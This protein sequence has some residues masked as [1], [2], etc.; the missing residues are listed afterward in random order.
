MLTI[1]IGAGLGNQLFMI[2]AAFGFKVINPTAKL[3]FEDHE[4][5]GDRPSY[6]NT[7][8]VDCPEIQEARVRHLPD[9]KWEK[10]GDTNTAFVF[11]NY[12]GLIRRN[13]RQGISTHITG[14][15]QNLRYLPDKSLLMK[16]FNMTE[17][18]DKMRLRFPEINFEETC[19][20]HFRLG[21]YKYHQERFPLLP[22]EYYRCAVE[23]IKKSEPHVKRIL[24]FNEASDFEDVKHRLTII[25]E[26][27]NYDIEYNVGRK[28]TDWEELVLM[29][30]CRSNIIANSTFSWW[31]AYL[32]CHLDATVICPRTWINVPD[33]GHWNL[34]PPSWILV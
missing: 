18:Q 23:E 34:A 9:G 20:I 1:P 15:F 13:V 8:F 6:W 17:K 4:R 3:V 33:S 16:I 29:S 7:F 32:N 28:L 2:A 5:G 31:S 10:H 24:I 12:Q 25:L 19:S 11:F 21:D 26:N 14:Y 27:L 22:N 30:M